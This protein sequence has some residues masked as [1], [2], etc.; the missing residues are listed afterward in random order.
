MPLASVWAEGSVN[1]YHSYKLG[2]GCSGL[3]EEELHG[4]FKYNTTINEVEVICT[5]CKWNVFEDPDTA[6]W[7]NITQWDFQSTWWNFRK[8]LIRVFWC[9]Q[10]QEGTSLSNGSQGAL[11]AHSSATARVMLDLSDDSK[12][13]RTDHVLRN[14]RPHSVLRKII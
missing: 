14:W 8:Q 4:H 2:K 5:L 7:A 1:L 10:L 11:P 9:E 3:I 12:R 6:S 13:Q